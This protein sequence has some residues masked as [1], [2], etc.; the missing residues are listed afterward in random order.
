VVHTPHGG[1][2][3]YGAY[4]PSVR[5]RASGLTSSWRDQS[6]LGK[7]LAAEQPK[8][9]IL[10]GDLN[11]TVHDRG[12][13]PPTSRL[14]VPQRGFAFSFPAALPLACI[15]QILARSATVARI[16][17]LPATGSDHLPVA[18]RIKLR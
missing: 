14:N 4:L 10:L 18:A 3:A 15:D 11:G 13:A 6:A 1:L 12:L 2:A 16:R 7:A 9:V 17:T 8:T 5:I